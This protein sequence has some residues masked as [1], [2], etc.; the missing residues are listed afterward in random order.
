MILCQSHFF[1]LAAYSVWLMNFGRVWFIVLWS[2]SDVVDLIWFGPEWLD[3]LDKFGDWSVR[4]LVRSVKVLAFH[5]M[6]TFCYVLRF[7]LRVSSVYLAQFPLSIIRLTLFF[8][9]S[10]VH[11]WVPLYIVL[12]IPKPNRFLLILHSGNGWFHKSVIPTFRLPLWST[13]QWLY[14]DFLS[15]L[16]F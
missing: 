3:L 13:I 14:L 5:P 4:P 6:V 11:D 12:A 7:F 10:R 16:L 9:S 1:Y 15:Q 8:V 2:N